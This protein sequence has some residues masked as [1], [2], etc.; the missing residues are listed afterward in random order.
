MQHLSVLRNRNRF[1]GFDHAV[2][3]FLLHFFVTNGD[4]SAAGETLARLLSES[5]VELMVGFP[6]ESREASRDARA[7]PA[8]IGVSSFVIACSSH[9]A[10]G[11]ARLPCQQRCNV[12]VYTGTSESPAA[13]QDEYSRTEYSWATSAVK[14][15]PIQI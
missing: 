12:F 6:S 8:A 11:D 15:C 9:A 1:S 2:D 13:N 5:T 3:V 4:H 14:M 7:S 10:F